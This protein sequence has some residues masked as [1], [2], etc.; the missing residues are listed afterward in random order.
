MNTEE[1]LGGLKAKPTRNGNGSRQKAAVKLKATTKRKTAKRVR[2]TA[3]HH[4]FLRRSERRRR[5]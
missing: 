1:V 4:P 2:N 5:S 3:L